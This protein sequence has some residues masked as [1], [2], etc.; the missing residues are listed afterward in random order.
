MNNIL[1]QGGQKQQ[2]RI[3][4]DECD[5]VPCECGCEEFLTNRV[6]I[7]RISGIQVGASQDQIQV[8]PLLVCKDCEKVL[9]VNKLQKGS[10]EEESKE[11]SS[12]II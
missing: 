5:T 6:N 10:P 11:E 3:N 9:D 2:I 4:L 1:N 7:K 8:L 12:I